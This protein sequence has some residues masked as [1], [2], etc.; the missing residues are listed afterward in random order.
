LRISI[1]RL[2]ETHDRSKFESGDPELDNYLKLYAW[3]NQSRLQIGTTYVATEESEPQRVIGYYTLAS[4]SIPLYSVVQPSSL[5]RLPY[6]DVPS[7]LLARLAVTKTFQKQGLGA[8]LLGDAV[9]RT[10]E[11][12]QVIGC[13]CLIVDAYP[14]AVRWYAR[15]GFIEV[16]PDS[17]ESRTRK[18]VLDLRTA[19]NAATAA[20]DMLLRGKRD[21]SR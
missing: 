14:S 11:F 5:R 17:P 3:Q 7:I 1:S 8:Q 10:L 4:T 20:C 12:T 9:R 16:S 21:A 13:R 19:A 6:G 2:E 18:M 15:F